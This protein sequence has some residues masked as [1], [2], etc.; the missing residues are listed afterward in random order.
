MKAT[1]TSALL[2]AALSGTML[3]SAGQASA[4]DLTGLDGTSTADFTVSTTTDPTDPTDPNGKLVLQAVPSFN[5][6]S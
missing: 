4:A 1:L 6:G 3:V 5:Y 2:L